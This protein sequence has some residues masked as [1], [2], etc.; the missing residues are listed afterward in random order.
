MLFFGYNIDFVKMCKNRKSCRKVFY[1]CPIILGFGKT[2]IGG[3]CWFDGLQ[4]DGLL[5]ES[6]LFDGLLFDGLLFDG[7]QFDNLI[8]YCLMVYSLNV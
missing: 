3:V 7:L 2:Y 4:F 1:C 6:L 8:V 5:F